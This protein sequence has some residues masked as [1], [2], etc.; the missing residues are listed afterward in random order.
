M[1]VMWAHYYLWGAMSTLVRSQWQSIMLQ[2]GTGQRAQDTWS[3]N[4]SNSPNPRLFKL[5][6]WPISDGSDVSWLYSVR[7]N[8]QTCEKPMTEHNPSKWNRAKGSR[9]LKDI[10]IK[11]T[12]AK[13]LQT[14]QSA[15]L[16]WQWSELINICEKQWA[17]LWDSN[18]RASCFKMLQ[19]KGL[20]GLEAHI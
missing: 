9:Y 20:K 19:D 11:L 5:E 10:F 6:S 3:I 4:L 18:D 12:Q 8:E 2:N 13:T 17:H 14:R 1:A 16:R 7:S 15:N